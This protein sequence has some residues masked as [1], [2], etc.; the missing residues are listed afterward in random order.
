MPTKHREEVHQAVSET[1]PKRI[2]FAA[3]CFDDTLYSQQPVTF[4]KEFNDEDDAQIFMDTLEKKIK[5]I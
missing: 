5:E 4:V 1:H 2:F 3:K